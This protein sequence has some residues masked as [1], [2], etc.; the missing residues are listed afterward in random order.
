MIGSITKSGKLFRLLG[1]LRKGGV[2]L[3]K[4]ETLITYGVLANSKDKIQIL[5]FHCEGCWIT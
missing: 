3:I 5:L 4:T 2:F 1:I